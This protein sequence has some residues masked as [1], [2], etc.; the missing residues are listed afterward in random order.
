MNSNEKASFNTFKKHIA[1]RG[2]RI[3]RIE[4]PIVPGIYDVSCCLRWGAEFWLEIKTPKEPKREGTSLFGSNHRVSTKQI[5]W[6]ISQTQAG[7]RA[8]IYI[9][10][11][12]RRILFDVS[13]TEFLRINDLS[14][15][16]LIELAPWSAPRPMGAEQWSELR[17]TFFAKS[18]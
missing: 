15:N 9:D 17:K 5:N 10:T 14:V 2:D 8:Y 18:E 16:E 12:R 13:S 3:D 6:G 4:C 1:R 11:D 7:G